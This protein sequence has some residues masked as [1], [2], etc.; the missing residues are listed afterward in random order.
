MKDKI[1]IAIATYNG[2]RFLREQL[3]SLYNQTRIPDEVIVCDD[4]S[5]DNTVVILEEYHQKYGLKYYINEKSL[6]VN[7]NFFKAISLCSGNYICICDQDD[8]WMP[9]KIETLYNAIKKYDNTKPCCVSSRVI[10]IN[11]SGEQIFNNNTKIQNTEGW[12]ATFTT[13]C[14]QGCTMILNQKLKDKVL[15]I[16]TSSDNANH[17]MYDALIGYVAAI[18][19]NKINLGNRLMFYRHHSSNVDW[20]LLDKQPTF[21]ER[22][23]K[24]P[25]FYPFLEDKKIHALALLSTIYK[26]AQISSDIQAF[27]TD[28]VKLYNYKSVFSGLKIICKQDIPFSLKTKTCFYSFSGAILKKLLLYF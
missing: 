18:E 20:K 4:C 13:N 21:K 12:F 27:L 6:G 15:Q 19:G 22:V 16:F 24:M 17:I 5:N 9:N 3:D 8:I 28:M 25:T 23:K 7:G 10:H 11:A 14:S 2:E 26:D 1:S